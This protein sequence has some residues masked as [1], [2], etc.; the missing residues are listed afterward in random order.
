MGT[1]AD[2]TWSLLP[3]RESRRN[4]ILELQQTPLHT[5]KER[6]VVL[7]K[8]HRDSGVLGLS[9]MRRGII[10]SSVLGDACGMGK[11]CTLLRRSRRQLFLMKRANQR[12]TLVVSVRDQILSECPMASINAGRRC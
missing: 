12:E 2:A 6:A 3:T 9:E 7:L 1:G 4:I 10:Q 11:T 5:I 8:P